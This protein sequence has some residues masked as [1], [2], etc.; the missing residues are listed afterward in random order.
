MSFGDFTKVEKSGC[1]I[2]NGSYYTEK[3][4]QQ[5]L[6]LKELFAAQE[7]KVDL[8]PSHAIKAFFREDGS[9]E[10]SGMPDPCDFVLFMDKDVRLAGMLEKAG[11]RLI[12]SAGA[13]AACDDKVQTYIDLAGSGL[14]VAKTIPAPMVYEG[15]EDTA[16]EF[17]DYVGEE[18]GFPLVVKE[19]YGSYGAQVYLAS[20][21][22]EL[23]KLHEKLKYRPHLYQ[24]FIEESAG[25]DIRVYV[26]GGKMV[27][28]MLRKC[29]DDFRANVSSGA[30]M[31]KFFVPADFCDM[32]E[33]A[34]EVLGL[35]Y[36]GVDILFGADGPVLC[37]VNSNAHFKNIYDCTGINV[38]ELLVEYILTIEP[39]QEPEQEAEQDAGQ[40]AGSANL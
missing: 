40:D 20:D 27:A 19:N 6:W 18:L 9:V 16:P 37:E 13:I 11:Y 3:I 38:A 17:L 32:A 22:A 35:D 24:E 34:A 31:E 12:N 10:A 29:A 39:E 4:S 1:I 30:C 5:V 7:C 36:C 8:L 33:R 26:L 2:Y 23:R 28:T 14:R 25:R 15:S 21:I